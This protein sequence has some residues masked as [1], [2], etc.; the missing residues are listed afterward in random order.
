MKIV[1]MGTPLFAVPIL[2]ALAKRYEVVLVVSQPDRLKKKNQL[3]PTPVH[4]CAD[5]LGIPCFQPEKV[6]TD[7]EVILSSGADVLIT[8]AYGQFIPSKVLNH[9]KKCLNVHGSLLPKYRGGAP[10][11]RSIMNLDEK[12]G[13][14]IMEMVKKMD[15]GSM[16]AKAECP[17]TESDNATSMFEKLSL[18]GRD[19]L[20]ANLEDIVSGK[21]KGTEQNEEEVTF[22]PNI[23]KE[24]EQ[25]DF[26]RSSLE[27][28]R[29]IAGLAMEPGAYFVVNNL[30]IKVFAAEA[31]EDDSSCVPGTV[32]S[33][34]KQ[35]KIKTKDQAVVLKSLLVPGKKIVSGK[36]FV[37]GQKILKEN[38]VVQFILL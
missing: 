28:I 19:L 31:A 5:R 22:A 3:L 6:S 10:I 16:Y 4:A 26:N 33:L 27:V 15:A 7:Y 38:D 37:N 17:I 12:T 25:I 34:Q 20:L 21:L 1:F 18:L 2:E 8:A 11:Q 23:R 35:I 32:L 30:K 36:D 13:V 24:E 29:Q 9:F 14:T